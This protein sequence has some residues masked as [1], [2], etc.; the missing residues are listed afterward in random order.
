MNNWGNIFKNV[1]PGKKTG[2]FA[3]VVLSG[4]AIGGPIT[5]QHEGMKLV[6]YYD[7][8]KVLTWCGGETEIGYKEKFTE[9][10][11]SDLFAIRY[12]YYSERT[13]LFYN[14]TAKEI[15]TPE[16]HASMVDMSYNLGLTAV[17]NSSMI[18]ELNAGNAS[19][20][21]LAILKY[22]YVSGRDCSQ[23]ENKK[24]CGGI[25]T[26][27]QMIYNLCMDGVNGQI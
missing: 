27:R 3:L 19:R 16:I 11:C 1:K 26:R 22:K 9:K 7:S 6:P 8:A 25:W 17:K 14:D 24:F 20:S 10:E 4:A 23:P 2:G 21:C 15:I 18:R 12:G 5:L 13:A